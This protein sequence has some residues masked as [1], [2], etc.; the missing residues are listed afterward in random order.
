MIVKGLIRLTGRTGL[1]YR[2]GAI[3]FISGILMLNLSVFSDV[4]ARSLF[5]TDPAGILSYRPQV[6]SGSEIIRFVLLAVGLTGLIGVGRGLFLLRLTPP[7]GGGLARAI[8][9][10]IGGILCMNFAE[11]LRI[12]AS[13]F[14]GEVEILITSVIG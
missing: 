11:F 10:M 8:V 9:H 7:E 2:R 1:D 6:S 4:L 3:T 5:G 13:G 14:G 12:L